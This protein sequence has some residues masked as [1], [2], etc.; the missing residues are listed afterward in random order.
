MEGR[1]ERERGE[2]EK[3]RKKEGKKERKRRKD[4]ERH[5][6]RIH[7]PTSGS[8]CYPRTAREWDG[9]LGLCK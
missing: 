9:S 5:K 2:R 6:S 8:G 4:R 7:Q 1:K 3:E